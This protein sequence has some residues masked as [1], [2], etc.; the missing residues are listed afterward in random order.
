M[1]LKQQAAECAVEFVKSGMV[2]G[3]GHGSTAIFAVRRLAQLLREG[4]LRKVVGV[5]CSRQVEEE[6]RR[7]DIP[8]TTLDEHPVV[9]VTIDGADEVDPHLNPSSHPR[10]A[11]AGRCRP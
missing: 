3:L 10:W 11:P 6:A 8:P 4:Q 5:P 1:K 9:D 2:V 7:L